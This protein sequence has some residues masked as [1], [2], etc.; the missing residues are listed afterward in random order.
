MTAPPPEG[1]DEEASSCCCC[2]GEPGG[3]EGEL[4]AAAGGF[5]SVDGQL[6]LKG[7]ICAYA[8][9]LKNFVDFGA[10]LPN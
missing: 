2:C 9:A 6:A 8:N 3:L 1:A 7:N 4:L 10:C 5:G